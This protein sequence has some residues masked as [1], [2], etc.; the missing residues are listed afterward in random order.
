M[1]SVLV[2]DQPNYAQVYNIQPPYYPSKY[3]F[4][5]RILLIRSFLLR[6]FP[7]NAYFHQ[8]HSTARLVLTRR[9]LLMR[10]MN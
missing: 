5:K 10:F 8:A 2:K 3:I 9:I 4:I 1:F 6:V 7:L